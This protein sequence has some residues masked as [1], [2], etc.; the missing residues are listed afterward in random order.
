ML[1]TACDV[2]FPRQ[3]EHLEWLMGDGG[4]LWILK[5]PQV[6]N[7]KGKKTVMDGRLGKVGFSALPLLQGSCGLG[8]KLLSDFSDVPLIYED[9]RIIPTHKVILFLASSCFQDQACQDLTP[10]SW[11]HQ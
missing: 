8:I 6:G 7:E 4:S 10:S 1:I 2:V 3:A 9:N 5:P 11:E